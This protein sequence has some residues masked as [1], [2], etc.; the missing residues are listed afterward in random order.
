MRAVPA[1]WPATM[2][3][4]IGA[5]A[6][7]SLITANLPAGGQGRKDRKERQFSQFPKVKAVLC[8]PAC[9]PVGKAGGRLRG[10]SDAQSLTLRERIG[11]VMACA[12]RSAVL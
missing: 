8:P 3:R 6:A 4:A 9:L 11:N 5:G 2:L 12:A 10:E 1:D 7:A